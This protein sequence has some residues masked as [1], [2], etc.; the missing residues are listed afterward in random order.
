[1]IK[2]YKVDVSKKM[3]V[4]CRWIKTKLN[5]HIWLNERVRFLQRN[6][7]IDGPSLDFEI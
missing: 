1:M 4:F 6:L 2:N 3:D 7:T 5:E